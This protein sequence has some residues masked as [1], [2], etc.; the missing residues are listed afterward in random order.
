MNLSVY[1][2]KWPVTTTMIFLA[3]ILLGAFSW[4]QLGVDLM[5]DFEIPAVSIITTY[6]GCGPREIESSITEPIEES[7]STVENVD[8]ITSTSMEGISMVTVK[9]DWGINLDAA[10]NDIRDKLDLVARRLPDNAD[11]PFIFKFNTSMIPVIMM[12]VSAEES[13]EKLD[14]IVDRKVVDSLKRITGVA[15][16]LQMGGDKRGILVNLDRE[17]I[18]A[19][20]LSGNQLVNL[21][22]NQ[23]VDNPGGTI[24][25]GQFEYLARTPGRFARV[26]DLK[27]VVVATKPGVVRLGDV[28]DIKDGF[29][30]KSNEFIING[31]R[32]IGVMV[33]KQSGANT[34][35]VAKAVREALPEI[36][37]QLPPDVKIEVVMD[38]SEFIQNTIN[39]LSDSVLLGGVAVFF[40]ILFFLKD[41]RG[42]LIICT[43]IPTSLIITFLL[44][45]MAGYT[46]N[47]ISLSS[48]AI[49]IGMV[50]DNSIVILDNIKRYLDRGVI[51]KDA[52]ISGAVEMGTSIMASTLTTI[53]I[54]LP[55]IFTTGLTNIMF[56][57]LAVIITMALSASLVSALMLTPMM[58]SK[59]LKPAMIVNNQVV[60]QRFEFLEKVEDLYGKSLNVLLNHPWKTVGVLSLSFVLSLG[61]VKMVGVDF[62]PEQDEGRITI[63]YEL[64]VGTRY[65]VTGQFGKQI[66][67]IVKANLREKELKTLVVRYGKQDGQSG[68]M[69]GS[70]NFSYAGQVTVMLVPKDQRKRGVKQ[71]IEDLRPLVAKIPGI[72]VIFD[73]GDPMANMMGAGGAGFTLNLYGYDLQTGLNWANQLKAKLSSI[74]GLADLEISQDL[75]Q[76][77]LQVNIDREKAA[78]LGFNV[79]DIG[80]T[81]ETYISGDTTVKYQEGGDEYDIVVRLRKEDRDK[82]TD[83]SR[84]PLLSPTGQTVMLDNLAKIKQELGPTSVTRNEQERYVQITGQVSGR[85][86]GDVSDDARAIIESM[87]IPP[88]FT[89]KFAGN[90]KQRRESFTVLLE[91]GILGCI[92]VYMVMA[93]QFE[94]L[95]APFIIA[96]SIPFGF[97]GA[98]IFLLIVGSRISTV[99]LLAFLI[100]IGIVVNNGI[101]LVSYVNILIRR[102]TGLREAL[103][104]SGISRLRPILST[105]ITTIL[106]MIPMAI[107]TGEG[108]EIWVPMGMSIIGGLVVSTLMTLFLMPVLYSLF[109]RWLVPANHPA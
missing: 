13:W 93:S 105:T 29:L 45:Y 99:S 42:S 75:A 49:A 77:E 16:A 103:V 9:F 50:V 54:F 74:P 83:L 10:T 31:K 4:T 7:V 37:S 67:E 30:E 102:K 101:V 28:A 22:R 95:L 14:K 106:G 86:S 26:D 19:T 62:M 90:E 24:K 73:S 51:S 61:L 69:S 18:Q 97:I 6:T 70:K 92:L 8:E 48:L 71:V 32:G 82:I 12:S 1:G 100:L 36:Q 59:I 63:K 33:Q 91:A 80:N 55:I 27:S 60:T 46:L 108:S 47:Q 78:T 64:P 56:G 3:T 89:W 66:A 72:K 88:G 11:K 21:L 96:L 58:C 81:I 94:S 79:S 57:Q 35:S 109:S 85:G 38:T 52:A 40:V 41:I 20:G 98:V 84:V 87:P 53:V 107:S 43:T 25:Q 104:K 39:N 23:N 44:M 15:T 76:P 68:A 5:P 34:V 17:R 65:E 2:V